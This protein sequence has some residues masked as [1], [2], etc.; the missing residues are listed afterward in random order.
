MENNN[1]L[2]DLLWAFDSFPLSL[3]EYS[4]DG[5][6][7]V[8]QKADK[9]I[10]ELL[11]EVPPEER[12]RF[13]LPAIR[14]ACLS[15]L[16]ARAEWKQEPGGHSAKI[17]CTIDDTIL[18]GKAVIEPKRVLVKMK[19]KEKTLSK[20]CMLL[21]WAPRLFTEEPFTGSPANE[22]GQKLARELFLLLYLDNMPKTSKA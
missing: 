10:S 4:K 1:N 14:R 11:P 3:E 9:Y 5:G 6:K 22:E 2:T 16:Y 7:T 15:L 13:L 21:D 19:D 20:A 17:Q 12:E 8:L 18:E